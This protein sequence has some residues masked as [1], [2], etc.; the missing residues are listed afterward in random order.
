M[1]GVAF[2]VEIPLCL[3]PPAVVSSMPVVSVIACKSLPTD[4]FVQGV[5]EKTGEDGTESKVP[6]Q[7][8]HQESS[9]FGVL[10]FSDQ[11]DG[12]KTIGT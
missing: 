8:C 7:A 3:R 11:L 4:L 2:P 12:A 1:T 5:A 6:S 9:V 10:C